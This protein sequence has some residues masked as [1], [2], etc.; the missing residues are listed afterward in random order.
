MTGKWC[1]VAEHARSTALGVSHMPAL[2]RTSC[3]RPLAQSDRIAP[4]A[5]LTAKK[6]FS[7]L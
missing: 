4:T 5:T 1:R 2:G 7:Q 6:D 3:D